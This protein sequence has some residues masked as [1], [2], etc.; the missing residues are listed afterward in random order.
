MIKVEEFITDED[1]SPFRRWFDA[2]DDHAAAW[3]TIAIDRLVEGNISNAK[4]LGDG[5]SELKINRG[6]GYRVY[7]GWDG[8]VLVILLGGGTKQRQQ[9]DIQAA[10]RHWRT[11]KARKAAGRSRRK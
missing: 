10:L 4:S 6:P 11:Y 3:V 8:K 9:N 5:I 1:V 7:F 2:L